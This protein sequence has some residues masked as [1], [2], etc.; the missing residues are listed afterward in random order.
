MT[1]E[2]QYSLISGRELLVDEEGIIYFTIGSAVHDGD[3]LFAGNGSYQLIAPSPAIDKGTAIG[4]PAVDIAGQPRPQDG[5]GNGT[6][7]FDIGA[8]EAP[9]GFI[10]RVFSPL[11]R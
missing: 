7:E 10:W 1:V 5:D 3:P 11:V 8:H 6:A 2:I 9:P 4:A